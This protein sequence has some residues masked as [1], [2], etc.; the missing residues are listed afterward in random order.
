MKAI[1]LSILVAGMALVSCG[2]NSNAASTD[3]V[4][5]DTVAE[6]NTEMILD[7]VAND[8]ATLNGEATP[9]ASDA[10]TV[11]T[12]ASEVKATDKPMVIDFSAT[13]CGPCQKFKPIYHKVAA[14]Y[15]DKATF[16]TA[17]VDECTALAQQYSVSS[18][19]MVLILKPD[20]TTVQN[21]GYMDE[22]EFIKFLDAN[23]K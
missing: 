5:A 17:D 19:P 22:A 1:Y 8:T 4:T 3:N 14:K 21:V 23:I 20:G 10:V 11:L 15:A 13:W 18:I 9:E 12:P 7:S 2:G 16:A 6:G